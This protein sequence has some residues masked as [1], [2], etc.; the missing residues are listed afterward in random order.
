[1]CSRTRCGPRT[2]AAAPLHMRHPRASAHRGRGRCS[3]LQAADADELVDPSTG[4]A[5]AHRL[6]LRRSTSGPWRPT[7][8]SCC[9]RSLA[10]RGSIFSV[11]MPQLPS[12]PSCPRH[13]TSRDTRGIGALSGPPCHPSR[14]RCRA[15]ED[16][17]RIRA[18]L[19]GGP[20]VDYRT[21]RPP[22]CVGAPGPAALVAL[23]F[24]VNG[25]CQFD[26]P[27]VLMTSRR[28]RRRGSRSTSPGW[29]STFQRYVE[30]EIAVDYVHVSRRSDRG[31][32]PRRPVHQLRLR[33]TVEIS[34]DGD[35]RPDWRVP[36]PI[37]RRPSSALFRRLFPW[38]KDEGM[39][40]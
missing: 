13:D 16:A 10:G 26:G 4:A 27:G 9:P 20:A 22:W 18:H 7:S 3:G 34:A 35:P 1:M 8:T 32:R 11:D 21:G 23:A 40:A 2:N 14:S 6:G 12:P 39:T 29:A 5:H 17:H 30:A 38:L 33:H 37:E 15:A 19:D 25:A 24:L 36:R 31:V 28:K